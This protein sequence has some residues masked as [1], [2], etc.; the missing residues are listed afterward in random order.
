VIN[1]VWQLPFERVDDVVVTKLPAPTFLLPR[2]KPAPKPRPPTK[3]EAYAK[4]KGLTKRKK[5]KLVWDDMV[6]VR[7][8]TNYKFIGYSL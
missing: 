5:A 3:W 1:A 2:E 4:E 7:F 6:K 8:L